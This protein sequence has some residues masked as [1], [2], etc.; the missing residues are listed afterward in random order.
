MQDKSASSD[1]IKFFQMIYNFK[2]VT[3]SQKLPRNMI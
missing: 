3:L 2:A 1:D